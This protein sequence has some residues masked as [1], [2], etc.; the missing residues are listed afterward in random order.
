[1][2][3]RAFADVTGF[4]GANTTPANRQTSGF[5][6]GAGLLIVGF[7]F[8][9]SDT[10]EDVSAGAPSL[11]TGMGNVLLQTP[12]AIAGIQPYFDDRRRRSISEA[13]GARTDSGFALGTRRRREDLARRPAAPAR[14][15]PGASSWEAARW[16]RQ[17]TASTRD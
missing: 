17:R 15:L 13:L 7:E 10:S 3:G 5:A 1:M 6:V 9:Y 2:P 8:E 12:V 16:P 4:I 11:K 14:G